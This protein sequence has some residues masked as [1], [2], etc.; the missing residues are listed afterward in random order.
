M[1]IYNSTREFLM[2]QGHNKM[3]LSDEQMNTMEICIY[4]GIEV[5]VD[6]LEGEHI[7]QIGRCT[8]SQRWSRVD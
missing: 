6:G 2:H 1:T 4:Q 8:A 3:Y 7:S 5:Q